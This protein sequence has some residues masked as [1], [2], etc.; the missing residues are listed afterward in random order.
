MSKK[1]LHEQIDFTGVDIDGIRFFSGSLNAMGF[2]YGIVV[3]RFNEVFTKALLHNT[4]QTLLESGATRKDVTV[5]WVPGAYEIPLLVKQFAEQGRFSAVI[6]LGAVLQGETPHAKLINTT[7]AQAFSSISQ[8]ENIPV[9]DGVVTAYNEE[10]M[11]IRCSADQKNRGRY[12]ALAAIEM[13]RV[14]AEVKR[15]VC[16]RHLLPLSRVKGRDDIR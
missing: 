9:I 1:G 11:Q 12:A 16:W 13:A 7:I 4:I 15:E 6:A 10:Q 2:S 3:S 14:C 8:K 5:V